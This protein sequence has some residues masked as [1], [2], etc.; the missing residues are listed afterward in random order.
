MCNKD[1]AEFQPI[2]GKY[3]RRTKLRDEFDIEI[4]RILSLKFRVFE[5]LR[6]EKSGAVHIEESFSLIP[7]SYFFSIKNLQ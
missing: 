5:T 6:M 2:L 7:L 4:I 3:I 1:I